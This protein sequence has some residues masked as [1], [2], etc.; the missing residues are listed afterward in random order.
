M[1]NLKIKL[2]LIKKLLQLPIKKIE[3]ID[4]IIDAKYHIVHC[5]DEN[6]KVTTDMEAPEIMLQNFLPKR[7]LGRHTREQV[8]EDVKNFRHTTNKNKYK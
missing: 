6:F 5:C 7:L 2:Q 1:R 3:V 4:R 8:A